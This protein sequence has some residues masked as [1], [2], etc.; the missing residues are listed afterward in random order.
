MWDSSQR[1]WTLGL[2]G[3]SGWIAPRGAI[4]QA[5]RNEAGR[6]CDLRYGTTVT[7]IRER[8]SDG[9]SVFRTEGGA[10]GTEHVAA[11]IIA[12]GAANALS[13]SF[14]ISGNPITGASISVY[15]LVD[16]V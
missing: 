4:D 15:A 13:R 14:G 1:I 5:L 12:S 7:G 10:S 2:D 11:V 9:K 8:R 6:V 3:R 16:G